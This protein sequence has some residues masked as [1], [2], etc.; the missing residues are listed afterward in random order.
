MCL[1]TTTLTSEGRIEV[2][3]EVRDFLGNGPGS[4]V[5]FQVSPMGDVVLRPAGGRTKLPRRI[6]SMRGSAVVRM[7]TDEVM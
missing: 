4:K 6:A 3:R 5:M 7:R 1:A 2:P